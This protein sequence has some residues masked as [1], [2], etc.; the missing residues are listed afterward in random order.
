MYTILLTENNEAIVSQRSR[1]MQRS[2]LVDDIHF[3]TLPTYNDMEMAPFTLLL[4]Y[5]L[6][7]TNEYRTE[8]LIKSDDLYKD[9]LEYKLPVDTCLTKEPGKVELQFTF[10][11]TEM[12]AD[13]QV[14]QRVRKVGPCF[15]DII[16]VSAWSNM[17][18][19]DALSAVDQR[20]L[21]LDALA[22]QLS[23]QQEMLDNTKADDLSY[24][25]NTLQLTANGKK[26]GSSHVLDQQ[27]E[28]DIVEFGSTSENPDTPKP[29]DEDTF[30]EF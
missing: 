29:D 25:N 23:E 1:I 12:D 20:I 22:N 16:P 13:G 9:Y 5:R 10:S 28:F 24:E 30:I 18:P 8:Y 15:I 26:I 27:S 14:I 17:I 4:E 21:M 3:L 7:V 2:K 11:K 19:D 6:P